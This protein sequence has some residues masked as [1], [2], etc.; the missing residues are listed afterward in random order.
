MNAPTQPPTPAPSPESRRSARS[1][2]QAIE[3]VAT[4]AGFSVH[5]EDAHRRKRRVPSETL[6][7]LLAALGL[8]CATR[9][10]AAESLAA[11]DAEHQH[12]ALPPLV[13][14]E[15]DRAIALPAAAIEAG[16]RYRIELESGEVIDGRLS[17]PRAQS[18]LLAP[19]AEPGYHQLVLND[20]HITLAVAP[21]RCHTVSDACLAAGVEGGEAPALWGIGAQ[22]YGLRRA[23]DGGIG[24][25]SALAAFAAESARRGAHALAISPAH[26][27]FSADP[28]KFSPYS[29][30]SRLF[31]NVAHIDPAAVLG[32]EALRETLDA[33]GAGAAWAALESE[34]LV[35][36]PRAVTLR[37]KVLRA[38][39]DRFR[40]HDC[41]Q[42][43]PL[44]AQF[45][46]FCAQGGRALEDH[47]RFE[48]LD[49]RQRAEHGQTHW[50]RWPAEL[51]D[52][53]RAEVD[54]F[55][56]EHRQEIDFHLFMQWLAAAGLSE[57]QRAARDAGMAIGLVA[58][59]AVGCDGA[60]SHAWS[61]RDDMLEGVS[62]GAPPDLFNQAGQAWGLTTF[63]PR[64]MRNQGFTAFIDMLRAT[65]AH[66]GGLRIDHVLG[67][68]RLWLVPEGASP[69][70][71]A[72]L[73][74]PI[75]D[76]LRLI[77]LESW[78]HRAIVIGEDLG[79][80]PAGLRDRLAEHGLLGMRV[81]WFER[82][83]ED[84]GFRAPEQWGA[85]S[86]AMTTTHDLPTVA[87][88]WEGH[89]I[90]WRS[91]I[92]QTAARPDG[93]DPVAVAQAERATDR[94]ALWHA[95]Q[96]AGIAARDVGA[97]PLE[98][99]PVD[100]ALAFVASTPTPLAL[101]P[102]EDLLGLAE[103]PNLPGSIDE[104]PNWRRRVGA[105]VDALFADAAFA[106]RLLAIARVRA[107]AAGGPAAP[108]PPRAS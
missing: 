85:S 69:A 55:A 7:A 22:L 53:R 48:A 66:A 9:E 4:R 10:E 96:Q 35:D 82:N 12:G 33:L 64:A 83:E 49:A 52:P 72:Y 32:D 91:R 16:T 84:G 29:P 106:D 34:P 24:D 108:E 107:S 102:L 28:G 104:H 8:P 88:W 79:T 3:R 1:A 19:I 98:E 92:G 68:R 44:A 105:P 43:S 15:C 40:A 30:S 25:Y 71:G 67:L 90:E 45:D 87:G 77:A 46:A 103:Q 61:Y 41:N 76:L 74:Y 13:T 6:A 65:F 95:L 78:R 37:L 51:T 26:A 80:V 59:L 36:W 27:M 99:P 73:S 100:E 97:P 50:R 18:A 38:L 93:K 14:A 70:D 11:L 17:A 94:E 47:A 21:S 42:R 31:L 57:A 101:Y 2:R 39:F 56:R 58:D 20:R 5:W 60:G 75:D 23:G 63:S 89:D 62:V 81:L 54:A 86:V